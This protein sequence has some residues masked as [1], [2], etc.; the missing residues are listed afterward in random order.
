[1]DEVNFEQ[2]QEDALQK[3]A[4][5][6]QHATCRFGKET[7]RATGAPEAAVAE[8]EDCNW[9]GPVTELVKHSLGVWRCPNGHGGTNLGFHAPGDPAPPIPP[10]HERVC[11]NCKMEIHTQDPSLP[12]FVCGGELSETG[13]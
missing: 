7:Y 10:Y 13:K 8:V 1:V 11:S 9:A 6:G 3:A 5:E 2:M 4:D 12:C